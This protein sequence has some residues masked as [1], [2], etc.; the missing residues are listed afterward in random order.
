MKYDTFE[1]HDTQRLQP[2]EADNEINMST[3]SKLKQKKYIS[4]LT[5]QQH[6]E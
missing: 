4:Y 6:K 3:P 1:V 5:D 2:R